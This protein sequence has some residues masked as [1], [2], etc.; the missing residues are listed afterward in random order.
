LRPQR[1]RRVSKIWLVLRRPARPIKSGLPESQKSVSKLERLSGVRH[2]MRDQWA[3]GRYAARYRANSQ[4][5]VSKRLRFTGSAV[6]TWPRN[7]WKWL[8]AD[9]VRGVGTRN[10]ATNAHRVR[11]LNWGRRQSTDLKRRFLLAPQSGHVSN[12]CSMKRVVL[13]LI[14]SL[15]PQ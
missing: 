2:T 11:V 15:S 1:W 7:P 10:L 6:R 9:C 4:K 5:S 12:F 8:C 13:E 14:E 3:F